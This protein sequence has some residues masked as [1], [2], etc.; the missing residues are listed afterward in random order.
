MKKSPANREY[1]DIAIIVPRYWH[2]FYSQTRERDAKNLREVPPGVY[3][4]V[5]IDNSRTGRLIAWNLRREIEIERKMD[6]VDNW[7]EKNDP[8]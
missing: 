1:C 2:F 4:H 5:L 7:T 8:K 6:P 3:S